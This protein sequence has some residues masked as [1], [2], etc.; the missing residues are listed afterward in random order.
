VLPVT[1]LAGDADRITTTVLPRLTSAATKAQAHVNAN[2]QAQLQP[3]ITDLNAQI[4]AAANST[5]GLAGT[6]LGYTPAEWNGNHE[7]LSPAR[8]DDQTATRQSRRGVRTWRRS[9]RYCAQAPAHRPRPPPR[10]ADLQTPPS[11]GRVVTAR[12]R[13]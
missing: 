7:L 9:S 6:V 2:N 8:S 13:I 3:L 10:R 5:N 1:R 4:S 12:H 11:S